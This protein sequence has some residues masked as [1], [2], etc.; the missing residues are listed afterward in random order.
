M[1]WP[2]QRAAVQVHELFGDTNDQ[3]RWVATGEVGDYKSAIGNAMEAFVRDLRPPAGSYL[4][5]APDQPYPPQGKGA[6]LRFEV[7]YPVAVIVTNGRTEI[8]GGDYPWSTYMVGS[9]PTWSDA[10]SGLVIP[11]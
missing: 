1:S 5:V 4:I 10:G 9:N 2:Q 8:V 6:S 11:R 3:G 7:R